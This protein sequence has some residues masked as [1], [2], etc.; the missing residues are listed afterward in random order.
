MIKTT[1]I[2]ERSP[3]SFRL[4][5]ITPECEFLDCTFNMQHKYLRLMSKQKYSTFELIKKVDGNGNF[6]P[7][8]KNKNEV[9]LERRQV[10]AQYEYAIVVRKE[11][12]EFVGLMTGAH[13]DLEEYFKVPEPQKPIGPIAPTEGVNMQ[14]DS[15]LSVVKEDE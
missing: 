14:P 2:E 8:T 4:I 10:D 3:I 1:L 12:E 6:I 5:P 15:K 9:Q 7:N 13:V 11:I